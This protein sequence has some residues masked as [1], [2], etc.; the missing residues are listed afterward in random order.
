[1]ITNKKK[2]NEK[3]IFF[4]AQPLLFF[5]IT[6]IIYLFL[7]FFQ[8]KSIWEPSGL[9]YF[10]FLADAFLN[11]QFHFRLMPPTTHDLILFDNKIYAYWPPFPAILM[12]PFVAIFGVNFS[13]ILFTVFLGS[14]NVSLFSI[15]M[16]ELNKKNVISLDRIKQAMIVIFFAFGTVYVTMVPLGRV[17][18][19]SS[20]VSIFCILLAYI[21]T[22]KYD[23][24]W[25]FLL[26]GIAISAA[27]TTR[28]HLFLVGIWPA[29]YLLSKNWKLPKQ[30][31]MKLIFVGL[32]PLFIS[33]LL[34]F[35]YNFTRF[36][37]IFDLGYAYHNMGEI[38]RADYMKYGGFNLHYVP[39]NLYY[40][41]IA[42][43]F[44]MKDMSNFFMGGSLFL[45]SPVFFA[46]FSAFKDNDKKISNFVLVVT[47]FL[48][49]I[50]I[51]LLMGTGFVQFGP[52][53][54]L[55]FIIPLLILTA[56]GMKYWNNR[57]LFLLTLIS[58]FQYTVG[59]FLLMKAVG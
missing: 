34:I 49:N 26:T 23:G 1:L 31:L 27:F 7:S 38:F 41:Y 53:Y 37:N 45:L 11:G 8:S 59:L 17:W 22:V 9:H 16:T 29:W 20:V 19:T 40:Q 4:Y 58:I 24:Y 56:I 47:I 54:T 32:L 42:Y 13:D 21:A 43:P 52:R 18:F 39:I 55:D 30:K 51:L 57:I 5:F 44:L 28:M 36:G 2:R 12:M 3:Y 35:Y 50:P 14:L 46:V 33:G 10:N 6:F 15:L 48:T 25:A